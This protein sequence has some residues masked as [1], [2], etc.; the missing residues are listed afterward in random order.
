MIFAFSLAPR[1]PPAT[2][3]RELMLPF[4]PPGPPLQVPPEDDHTHDQGEPDPEDHRIASTHT[5]PIPRS[6]DP[7]SVRV[8]PHLEH[9]PA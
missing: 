4:S 8:R 6:I 9:R 7:G 1:L 2:P 3:A 5:G